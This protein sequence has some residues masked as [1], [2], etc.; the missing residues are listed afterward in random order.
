MEFNTSKQRFY[1]DVEFPADGGFK[2]R[3][4]ADWAVNWGSTGS[5]VL[6]S[7]DNIPVTAGNY[8]VYLNMNN[9]GEMTYELNAKMY[10]QDENAGNVTPEPPVEE[11][12]TEEPIAEE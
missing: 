2:F 11:P 12:V 5:G 4:D 8:R 7:G 3:A 9:A 10:G 6:D 1:A